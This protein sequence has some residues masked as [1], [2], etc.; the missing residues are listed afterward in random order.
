MQESTN[1]AREAGRYDPE[2]DTVYI[3][4]ALETDEAVEFVLKHE[5]THAIEGSKEYAQL[6]GLVRR[7]MGD[8][9]FRL[10]AKQQARERL[11]AGDMTG[12]QNAEKEVVA[13]W[14]GRNLY[15]KGFAQAVAGKS[16]PLATELYRVARWWAACWA[17]GRRWP[18]KWHSRRTISA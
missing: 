7:E 8:G 2:S 9:M 14:I 1:H 13:D 15:Q 10:A 4:A 12:A 3:N 17:P 18:A 11:A 16:R 6:E 5:L